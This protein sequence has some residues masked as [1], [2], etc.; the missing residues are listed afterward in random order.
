V[1]S[2]VVLFYATSLDHEDLVKILSVNETELVN[3]LEIARRFLREE[4]VKS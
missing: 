1:R 3:E 4:A 2:A